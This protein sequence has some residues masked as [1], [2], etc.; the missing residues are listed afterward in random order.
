M[1]IASAQPAAF[2]G[3]SPLTG[4]AIAAIG[5]LALA[6]TAAVIVTVARGEARARA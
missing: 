3:F 2:L 1:G 5:T 6:T 4:T